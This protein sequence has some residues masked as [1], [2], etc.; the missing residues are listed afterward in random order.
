MDVLPLVNKAHSGQRRSER[1]RGE[2]L[3]RLAV[4]NH[5]MVEQLTNSAMES[6]G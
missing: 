2:E 6:R 3:K 1:K 5:A 4:Q